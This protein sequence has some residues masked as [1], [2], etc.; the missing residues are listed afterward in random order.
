IGNKTT[1]PTGASVKYTW[2]LSKDNIGIQ[3]EGPI[4]DIN[5]LFEFTLTE[6]GA[7]KVSLTALDESTLCNNTKEITINIYNAPLANFEI[8]S[9]TEL[10]VG[11]DVQFL[12]LSEFVNTKG[13]S[14]DKIAGWEWWFDYEN[15]PNSQSTDQNPT[16]VFAE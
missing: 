15:N 9:S 4:T 13:F 6:P 8:A 2:R 16:H 3:T 14:D 7:Y 1:F 10:C 12:D 11:R 5:E